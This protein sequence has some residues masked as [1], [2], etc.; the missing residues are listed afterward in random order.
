MSCGHAAL[1][2]LKRQTCRESGNL[3]FDKPL[4]L[5]RVLVSAQPGAYAQRTG[6]RLSGNYARQFLMG[7]Q[8]VALPQRLAEPVLDECFPHLGSGETALCRRVFALTAT[9]YLLWRRFANALWACAE[10]IPEGRW[11]SPRYGDWLSGSPE[12]APRVETTPVA[13]LGETPSGALAPQDLD[14]YARHCPPQPTDIIS[15]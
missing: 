3:H 8:C 14:D 1:T 6:A 12:G 11:G 9:A 15:V 4:R 13:R 7:S 10:R 2:F 5:A